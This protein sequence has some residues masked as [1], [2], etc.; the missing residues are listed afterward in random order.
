MCRSYRIGGSVHEWC[1]IIKA[2]QYLHGSWAAF[3]TSKHIKLG[4]CFTQHKCLITSLYNNVENNYCLRWLWR[5]TT[6]QR[7]IVSDALA[8]LISESSQLTKA[9]GQLV[10]RSIQPG[11][12]GSPKQSGLRWIIN[13][14]DRQVGVR[15][16]SGAVVSAAAATA[17]NLDERRCWQW[18]LPKLKMRDCM[19]NAE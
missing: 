2:N 1:E 9:T 10:R 6:E 12:G 16:V 15:F 7:W 11:Y 5:L 13:D 4:R 3:C 14:D 18:R 17:S 19:E 8:V